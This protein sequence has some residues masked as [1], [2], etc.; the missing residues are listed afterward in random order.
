MQYWLKGTGHE[1]ADGPSR[2]YLGRDPG[3]RGLDRH[4]GLD[5]VRKHGCDQPIRTGL[6]ERLNVSTPCHLA[7]QEIAAVIRCCHYIEVRIQNTEFRIVGTKFILDDP[8]AN[9][10]L[11]DVILRWDRQTG[12]LMVYQQ[13]WLPRLSTTHE[14]PAS[15]WQPPAGTC[16]GATMVLLGWVGLEIRLGPSKGERPAILG[17]DRPD[18]PGHP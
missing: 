10:G 5:R 17:A 8:E 18:L 16:R 9:D 14:S 1:V 7:L 15:S 4:R 2:L 6:R 12:T 3:L 13:P 11:F